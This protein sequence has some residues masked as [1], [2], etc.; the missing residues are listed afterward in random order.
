VQKLLIFLMF[1][2]VGS[3]LSSAV[4]QSGGK[5]ARVDQEVLSQIPQ[6]MK[7]FIDR[8]TVAGAVTLVAHGSDIVEFEAAGMAD[9]KRTTPCA[10]TRFF[11]LCR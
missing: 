6:R 4:A 10:K 2:G 8:Q 7:S 11:R 1:V 9:M 5:A 3:T